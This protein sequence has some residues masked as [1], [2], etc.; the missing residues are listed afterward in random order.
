MN[1]GNARAKGRLLLLMLV[2][3]AWLLCGCSSQLEERKMTD[4]TQIPIAAPGSAPVEDAFADRTEHVMLY[5]LS[6]DGS[7]L[8]PVSREI[9]VPGGVS[10]ARAALQALLGGPLE[11]EDGVWPDLG[12]PIVARSMEISGGVA[13]VDLPARV[14]TLPQE[15]LYAMR[16]AIAC[17]LTEF[18][19]IH[20]V[21]VLIGGREEGFDLGAT[22][23]VGA[24]QRPADLEVGA[25][26]ARLDNLRQGGGA[27][28]QPVT[29]Y[30]PA[31]E[32]NYV[33]PRVQSVDYA[34]MTPIEYLYTLLDELGTESGGGAGIASM[35]APMLFINEMPE[36]VRTEDGAYRAIEI[37]FETAIDDA[38]ASSGL[39]RDIYMA[40]LTHTLMGAVP[41]VEGLQVHIGD[42]VITSLTAEQTSDGRAFSF[43]QG[44]ATRDDFLSLIG[45]PVTV[46]AIDSRTGGLIA[47]QRVLAQEKSRSP[48]ALLETLVAMWGDRAATSS[49]TGGDILAVS[50]EGEEIAVNLSSAF[51]D[52]LCTLEEKEAKA[53]VYAMVN[54]LTQNSR[55][56]TVAFFFDGVQME[57]AL[58]GV[59][60]RG[61]LARNPGMV[62]D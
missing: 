61:R 18:S 22:L 10:I 7:R 24:L 34:Q 32:G 15:T 6:E 5:F 39:T 14:R 16:V 17:T 1:T 38:L 60:M 49:L 52:A 50:V 8:M 57:E 31:A 29:L 2:V 13:I 11:Y 51:A 9:T 33:L 21:N 25:A 3:C 36:I 35:P 41:G 27:F 26:Y 4:V 30:L 45:A 40:V 48:R 59:E 62:V 46:Y 20:A 54:T 44:L 58:G 53:A 56:G 37:R 23:A 42:E 19:D 55:R 43:A 28:T 12:L 47:E